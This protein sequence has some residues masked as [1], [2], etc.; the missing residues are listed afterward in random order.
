[1]DKSILDIA[2]ENWDK[3]L[4]SPYNW[5]SRAKSQAAQINWDDFEPIYNNLATKATPDNDEDAQNT[6]ENTNAERTWI[7]NN[8]PDP[9]MMYKPGSIVP[10]A[11]VPRERVD[12]EKV[13]PF[14]KFHA[15]A[16]TV[17]KVDKSDIEQ[18]TRLFRPNGQ[19]IAL[20]GTIIPDE[21]PEENPNADED[22]VRN[23]LQGNE[24][25]GGKG[26]NGKAVGGAAGAAGAGVAGKD[27]NQGKNG[28]KKGANGAAGA[29]A[30]PSTKYNQ[31]N[32]NGPKQQAVEDA[33]LDGIMGNRM[34]RLRNRWV[35]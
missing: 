8:K 18:A 1:M 22:Q 31:V 29:N 21:A 24:E 32:P 16:P 15:P 13:L 11:N 12:V 30:K 20:D 9:P 5:H 17:G 19:A 23:A 25:K 33:E 28:G 27:K 7:T 34:R 6:P 14:K 10:P 3:Y 35:E 2:S 4:R 26:K